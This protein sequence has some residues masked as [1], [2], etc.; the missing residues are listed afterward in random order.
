M[1]EATV[2]VNRIDGFVF[3]Y[4]TGALEEDLPVVKFTSADSKLYGSGHALAGRLDLRRVGMSG[5]SFE[6]TASGS[7]ASAISCARLGCLVA[8]EQELEIRV[9]ELEAEVA[10]LRR[11]RL[12][13]IRYRSSAA[14]G[15]LPLISV[16]I[17]PDPDSGRLRGHA[18]GVVAIGDTAIGA[19]AIGGF[20]AGGIC[21]GGVSIGL[22]SFGGLALGVL[23]AVGGAAVGATAIGGGAVGRVAIGGGAAGEYACGGGAFGTHVVDAL[24]R[25]PEAERF[26]EEHG[27]GWLCPPA[28]PRRG[29]QPAEE[30][31]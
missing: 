11:T 26:F 18:R 4:Q 7:P 15:G 5:H 30:N 28:P 14:L 25:D 29:R 16:A 24:R 17:G 21:L 22:A 27:L 23:L 8:T 3:P 6:H 20:A 13:G 9:R 19:V 2:F 12:R 1:G 10:R 31:R